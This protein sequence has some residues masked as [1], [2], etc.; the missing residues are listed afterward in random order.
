MSPSIA[1]LESGSADCFKARRPISRAVIY[2][3]HVKRLSTQCHTPT[4][5]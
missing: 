3:F 5:P 1:S 2:A 4:R